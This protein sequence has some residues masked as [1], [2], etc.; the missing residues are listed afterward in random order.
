VEPTVQ[1]DGDVTIK[2]AME[3]SNLLREVSGPGGSLA[4]QVGT[5]SSSTTLRLKDGE[6]QVL[7]GLINDE[8]RQR[9]LGVPGLS[10]APV[11]GK[12]FGTQSDTRNKTEV[13]M[14]ITPRI[15]RQLTPPSSA[16]ATIASGTES[17]PGAASLRMASTGSARVAAGRGSAGRRSAGRQTDAEDTAAA[18]DA[19]ATTAAAGS[20]LVLSASST[21]RVGET[22]SVTLRNES[23]LQAAG[24]LAFDAL[25]LQAASGGSD[26]GNGRVAFEMEP[27]GDLVVVFRVLPAA[28]GQVLQVQVGGVRGSTAEGAAANLAVEGTAE[29]TVA[30]PDPAP[31]RPGAQP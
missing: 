21:A 24:A 4:Y 16:A 6:T 7:A 27:R 15:L 12:L 26:A 10:T 3:V 5:R 25:A 13:V 14:L 20:R 17:Q 18:P 19:A 8:D 9:A 28:A 11:L 30:M 2:V 22:V 1:L 29:I 31:S 23:P